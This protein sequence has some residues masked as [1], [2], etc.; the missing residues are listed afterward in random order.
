MLASD[1][2]SSVRVVLN[3][4]A[5]VYWTDSEMLGWVNDAQLVVAVVRPDSVSDTADVTLVAGSKQS[6]P[7]DGIRLLDIVR[8]TGG[9]AVRLI[10]RETLD[11]FDPS[12]HTGTASSTVKHYVYDNRVPMTFYVYPPATAGSSVEMT[13]SKMPTPATS[14]SSALTIPE[15]YKDIMVN[16]VLFRAYSK[17][18][19]HAANAGLAST[20]LQILNS[21]TGVKLSKDVAF[22]P[23]LNVRGDMPN[24]MAIQTGGV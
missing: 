22:Q 6:L 16:Y 10:E 21:L 18:A 2:I 5:G 14:A 4:G 24:Q 11:L 8:N 17:D 9:R 1:I 15:I 20:Y 12:W 13:Y 19:E 23:A 7:T 3:D